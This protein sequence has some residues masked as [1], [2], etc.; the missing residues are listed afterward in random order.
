MIRTDN[1]KKHVRELLKQLPKGHRVVYTSSTHMKI[2]DPEGNV[3]RDADGCVIMIPNSPSRNSTMRNQV[4]RL[5][6]IG[7][8]K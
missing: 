3:L 1:M 7:A 8:I 5:R 2:V 6:R 4:A